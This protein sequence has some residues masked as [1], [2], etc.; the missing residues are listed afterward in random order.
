MLTIVLKDENIR[1][2]STLYTVAN[3]DMA[4]KENLKKAT[5]QAKKE[6]KNDSNIQVNP[7]SHI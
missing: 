5:T 2:S 6:V 3:I 4:Q 1:N 7:I